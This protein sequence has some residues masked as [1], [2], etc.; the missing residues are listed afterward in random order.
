M[1]LKKVRTLNFREV[2][3]CD[4]SLAFVSKPLYRFYVGNM[5]LKTEVVCLWDEVNSYKNTAV[6]CGILINFFLQKSNYLL[7]PVSITHLRYIRRLFAKFVDSPYYSKSELDGG[8]VTASFS[9]YL[10]WQAMH[11]LTTL[12]PILIRIQ[13]IR[14]S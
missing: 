14:H 4:D 7:W 6:D 11:L 10:H 5:R 8:A 9:K 1:S 12:H 3:I 13:L 2:E